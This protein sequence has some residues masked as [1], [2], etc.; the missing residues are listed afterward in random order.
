MICLTI[1]KNISINKNN[2]M[3]N[4]TI[5]TVNLP[6]SDYNLLKSNLE[7]TKDLLNKATTTI[8][9]LEKQQKENKIVILERQRYDSDYGTRVE[10]T[11]KYDISKPEVAEEL[12]NVI[13]KVDNSELVTQLRTKEEA[14]KN[15]VAKLKETQ[16]TYE[17]IMRNNDFENRKKRDEQKEELRKLKKGYEEAILELEIDK[18]T[19]VKALADLKKDKTAEQI[20]LARQ[21]EIADLKAEISDLTHLKESLLGGTLKDA[22]AFRKSFWNAQ[23]FIAS[24]SWLKGIN[25]VTNSAID[26]VDSFVSLMKSVGKVKRDEL[27]TKSKS[28]GDFAT[29]YVPGYGQ[30][31]GQVVC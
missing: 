2:T 14:L 28:R 8:N 1:D 16:E 26:K 5:N 12:L 27:A 22:Y 6:L 19:L 24:H 31:Y 21:Q 18:E 23:R 15:A 4:N 9:V 7:T 3:E 10:S 13:S 30:M 25:R 29:I 20:E 17:S 11:I